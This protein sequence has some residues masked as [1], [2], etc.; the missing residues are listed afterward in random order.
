[1]KA[2]LV[3]GWWVLDADIQDVFDTIDHGRL[4]RLV[5]RRVSD[6]RVL[7]RIRQWLTVGVVE[8]GRWQATPKGTPQGGVSALRSTPRYCAWTR[9]PTDELA[10]P[11]RRQGGSGRRGTGSTNL[12]GARRTRGTTLARRDSGRPHA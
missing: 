4:L 6:R 3:A 8:D 11:R 1:V 12:F 10:S 7:K 2:A 9:S 5:Q